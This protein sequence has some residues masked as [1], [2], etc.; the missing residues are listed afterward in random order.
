MREEDF[1][2]EI[3]K[4]Y[5]LTADD[6]IGENWVDHEKELDMSRPRYA[7]CKHVWKV[8]QDVEYWVDDIN[9]AQKM[10]LK[11][12]QIMSKAIT[13]HDT[14][15]PVCIER[16]VSKRNHETLLSRICKSPR[17]AHTITLKTNWRINLDPNAEASASISQSAS[18]VK[19]LTVKSRT[20]PD[21]QKRTRK[22]KTKK[23]IKLV[24]RS[25]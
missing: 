2:D 8:A 4:R 24:Q 11:F 9:R 19:P 3:D 22:M 15:P 16:V 5:F 7:K 6:P 25:L 14:L 1:T 17:P 23:M 13:H 18:P 12:Y 20:V 21:Q 10:G